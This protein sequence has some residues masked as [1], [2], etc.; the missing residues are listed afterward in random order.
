MT[1]ADFEANDVV[2]EAKHIYAPLII[3]G[4]THLVALGTFLCL[5]GRTWCKYVCFTKYWS[6]TAGL[7]AIEDQV[8]G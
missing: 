7:Q 4:A 2:I 5:L 8:L 6:Y 3:M 1:V